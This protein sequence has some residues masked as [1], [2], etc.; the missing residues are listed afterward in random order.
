MKN[1][2]LYTSISVM[3]PEQGIKA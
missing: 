2:H 1:T 3:S